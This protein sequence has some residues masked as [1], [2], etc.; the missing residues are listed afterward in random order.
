MFETSCK[1]LLSKPDFREQLFALPFH[2]FVFLRHSQVWRYE[3]YERSARTY[4][5][6]L[7]HG[8][9]SLAMRPR[10]FSED[11]SDESWSLVLFPTVRKRAIIYARQ[12]FVFEQNNGRGATYTEYLKTHCL[13]ASKLLNVGRWFEGCVA[14]DEM[15]YMFIAPN[16]RAA[17][18]EKNQNNVASSLADPRLKSA[19]K[20]HGRTNL[21]FVSSGKNFGS[22]AIFGRLNLTTHCVE[23]S[24]RTKIM[25]L[26]QLWAPLVL[27]AEKRTQKNSRMQYKFAS[28][29]MREHH[30]P[31]YL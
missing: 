20:T 28:G 30:H 22:K 7:R 11:T 12:K 25:R 19:A 9:S 13:R 29:E 2:A 8:R 27:S 1:T 5:N 24:L 31:F 15:R 26:G 18:N 3:T 10:N 21:M 6:L 16:L 17:I 23:T 14:V 4:K